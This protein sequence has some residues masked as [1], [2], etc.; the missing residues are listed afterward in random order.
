MVSLVVMPAAAAADVLALRSEWALNTSVLI[1]AFPSRILSHLAIVDEH[2]GLW[3]LVIPRN[4]VE[5]LPLNKFV[6]DSYSVNAV[7]G[8]RRL[9]CVSAV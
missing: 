6:Q 3:G 7:T 2:T 5:W 4:S 1:P 9:S 8:H